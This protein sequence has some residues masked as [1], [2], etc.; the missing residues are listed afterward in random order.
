MKFCTSTTCNFQTHPATLLRHHVLSRAV[1]V[2]RLPPSDLA[3][4][5]AGLF[6]VRSGW[7]TSWILNPS[8]P[9]LSP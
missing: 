7:E 6:A 5:V 9:G 1:P 4:P 2:H 8:I 3:Y